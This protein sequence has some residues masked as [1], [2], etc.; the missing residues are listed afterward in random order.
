MPKS[1]WFTENDV[2]A[3]KAVRADVDLH[4]RSHFARAARHRQLPDDDE[5]TVSRRQRLR[6]EP[7]LRILALSPLPRH[8][9]EPE[10]GHP[11]AR[12][13][14]GRRG[15]GTLKAGA[16][17]VI[18]RT[19]RIAV[20]LVVGALSCGRDAERPAGA[21]APARPVRPPSERPRSR[22]TLR[23][24]PAAP[25]GKRRASSGSGSTASTGS[26]STGSPRKARCRTG[27]GSSPRARRR[28]S[29]E[30]P[31]DPLA[32]RLDDARDR[33][34]PRRAPG[35]RLPGGG[36]GQRA[37]GPDLGP[38]ARGAR[39]LEPRVRV[40][41]LG[42]RGRAGGHA[43]GR[44]GRGLLRLRP[45]EPDPLR[46]PAARGRR[47]SGVPRGGRRA[48]RRPRGARRPPRSSR[49]S[50]P[51]R[52]TRSRGA[53]AS[54]AGM[55]N[56]VVALARILGATRV[57][58][59]HR[60]RALRPQP[61]RPDDG[62]PRGH[63]RD[64]PRLRVVRAA[65]P[66]RASPRRTSRATRR[67]VDEYYALVD[68]I[69]GQWM[70]R[71]AGRR[72]DARSST[73]TTASS[74]APTG[75]ASAL[76]QLVHGRLL[77][78][79][80][81][82]VRGLGR[83]GP[84]ERRARPGLDVRRRADRSRRCSVCR[85]T[86]M[87]A[88]RS[89]AAFRGSG[90]ARA[91]RTSF[92]ACRCAASRPRRCRRSRR[93]NT[94][95]SSWRSAISP[96]AS[97]AARAAGRRPPGHDRG[98]LEQPRPLR[99][100]TAEELRRAR[101]PRSRR[102]S[103]CGPTIIRRMFNLAVLYREQQRRPAGPGLA[104]PLAR[105]RS[106]RPARERRQLGDGQYTAAARTRSHARRSSSAG[107]KAYPDER[108][109][110]RQL[111]SRASRRTTV[112]APRRRCRRFA[113]DRRTTRHPERARPSR[114]LPRA[115]GR[116]HR[117]LSSA[118]SPSSP[119]SPGSS[120][121]SKLLQKG[122]AV[123]PATALKGMRNRRMNATSWDSA[124]SRSRCS[125]PRR[126]R[127]PPTAAG[128]RSRRPRPAAS[129]ARLPGVSR[130]TTCLR[131]GVEDHGREGQRERLPGFQG[132]KIKRTRQVPE[133][134][135][136]QDRLRL[137]R[138]EVVLRRR[139]RP[140]TNPR[141]V[142]SRRRP[143]VDRGADLRTCSARR[144]K[145]TLAP[146][147]DAPGSRASS[148]GDRDGLRADARCPATSRRTDALL[149]QGTIFDFQGDPRE[150]RKQ[151]IDLSRAALRGKPTA[152][153][154]IVEYAD[155]ECGYCQYRGLQMDALLEANPILSY[156]RHYKFFPLWFSH[157]WAMK[158]A[159]R[160]TASSG[161]RR[162]RRCSRSRSRSTRQQADDGRRI[163]ELA[164]T[165]AEAAGIPRADFLACYLRDESFARRAQGH[166]GGLAAR[167]QLDAD[168]LHRRNRDHVDRG[169]G[170]GGL[171]A[172]RPDDQV[173]RVRKPK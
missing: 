31:P 50:S 46:E 105:G 112:R 20:L 103:R 65:A 165:I 130:R 16:D 164:L 56:P 83:A 42:R 63:R 145:A 77:A 78:P 113:V 162:R 59:A 163:D 2:V 136:R 122:R 107:L 144:A 79:P 97:P 62:L 9:A 57:E 88:G 8:R 23:P 101:R 173:D 125:A 54:G 73:P 87:P 80:R 170:D 52:R 143:G 108:A 154:T 153:I 149:R 161:S 111:A 69:L 37:E 45:R 81:R 114:D 75:P 148:I 21:T 115:A 151:R 84:P 166:R 3:R 48:G 49:A 38:L 6:N 12:G 134:E 58:S 126:A 158:A 135:R 72:R 7:D 41:R 94:R 156:K 132:Y 1:V 119:T 82:R 137:R 17:A 118:P 29:D 102:R 24:V 109:L 127:A 110:A 13:A 120:S 104:L 71:A 43:S 36:S 116:S 53:R 95:R 86:G 157:V 146:E 90:G 22:R 150:E 93:A 70:R 128:G 129:R 60:A 85:S 39:R 68:R 167:R 33:R 171:P 66:R 152:T 30:L 74:G 124:S 10:D 32:G 138:R 89:A 47:V 147:R 64:R 35:A 14:A 100:A 159:S 25:G 98:R 139:R 155:M 160:P 28:G 99:A 40:G 140:N 133:A 91:R 117:L 51:C 168:L 19:H 5:S 44:G 121:P 4:I 67:A 169:Q 96:A 61:A 26:S 172:R 76:A 131:P 141:P 92:R 18:A 55:E 15:G 11:V 142:Q 34:R 27:S 106:C 123:E